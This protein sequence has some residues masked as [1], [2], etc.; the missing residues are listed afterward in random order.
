MSTI[1]GVFVIVFDTVIVVVVVMNTFESL[2]N[3]QRIEARSFAY[4]LVQQGKQ[5]VSLRWLSTKTHI[6]G[7][8]RYGYLFDSYCYLHEFDGVADSCLPSPLVI[9][10]R[11]R[12]ILSMG[13]I[14]VTE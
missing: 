13:P 12:Y 10:L 6:Q 7:F 1:N 8:I 9:L 3:T 4:L 11:L 2:L 14:N 5:L